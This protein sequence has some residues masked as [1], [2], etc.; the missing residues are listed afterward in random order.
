M[1]YSSLSATLKKYDY[2]D[3]FDNLT[4]KKRNNGNFPE[5]NKIKNI[6]LDVLLILS[7]LSGT[8]L[9][10]IVANVTTIYIAHPWTKK[11]EI[12]HGLFAIQKNK[13]TERCLFELCGRR[14]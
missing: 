9:D 4:L 5:K 7:V 1:Y 3:Y 12:K 14:N 6:L 13:E 10:T 2:S 11:I 8:P